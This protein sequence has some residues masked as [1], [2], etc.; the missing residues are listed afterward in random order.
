MACS[1]VNFTF[2]FTEYCSI[3]RKTWAVFQGSRNTIPIFGFV[4]G[5]VLNPTKLVM[6]ANTI[7]NAHLVK[8]PY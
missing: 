8:L 6:N 7:R 2:T 1:R 4:S 5:V 3:I